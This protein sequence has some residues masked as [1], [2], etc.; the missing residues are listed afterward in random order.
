[1]RFKWAASLKFKISLIF[2]I[3]LAIAFSINLLIAVKA[4][5]TQKEEDVEKVLAHLLVESRD[6]Y[7]SGTQLTPSSDINFLYKIPHNVM[8]IS[9]SEVNALRFVVS[10]NPYRTNNK[11]IVSSIKLT[12]NY[13]LNAISDHRKI[14]KATNKYTQRLLL[15]YVLSLI[16]ILIIA[17][18]TLDFYMK[19]LEVLA[20][21]TRKWKNDSAFDLS[22]DDASSEI[23]EVST[24]FTG[25]IKR[26]EGY[27]LKEAELFRE[28]AHEL[29]TPLALMRSRLDVYD[30]SNTYTKRQFIIDLGND[31]E[32]LTRELKNVLFLE[33]S[34]F[35]EASDIEIMH[36]FKT[37][38]T[39]MG[40]LIQRKRLTLQLPKETFSV[41]AS[42]KLLFKVLGALLENAITY[43]KEGSTVEIG[44]NPLERK[45]WIGNQI[46][47]EKYLFSSK[48]GEKILKRL[49][50]EIGF[51]YSIMHD[52]SSFSIELAFR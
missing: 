17:I 51:D 50:H 23:K 29:K 22:L 7:I 18:F 21:K 28:A 14:D 26:L 34:D 6:E 20:G 52:E 11:I 49:S 37:L 5:H 15:Q 46:G 32:R 9:D 40:I 31:I 4:I 47:N 13:Y 12:N 36:M 44:C 48:I 45:F 19:P 38:E 33:S 3:G 24:A 30:S 43:A 35:E 16:V 25:L 10:P 41:V 42:E 8:I 27:R 2:A 39:K 1:M